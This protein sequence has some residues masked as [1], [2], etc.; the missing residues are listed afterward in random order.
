MRSAGWG[1]VCGWLA[2]WP[3]GSLTACLAVEISSGSYSVSVLECAD[4]GE[5]TGRLVVVGPEAEP[6]DSAVTVK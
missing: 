6:V 3:A 4:E 2:G 5:R 1:G